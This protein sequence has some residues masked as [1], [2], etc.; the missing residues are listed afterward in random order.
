VHPQPLLRSGAMAAERA[1][2]RSLLR[3]CR[4][5]DQRPAQLVPLL[6]RPPRRYDPR[7][8][9]SL[10]M[11]VTGLPFLEDAVREACG[12]STE[13]C[14]PDGAATRAV[15]R[16]YSRAR[17]MGLPYL[18]EAVLLRRRLE[19]AQAAALEVG[20]G[21]KQAAASIEGAAPEE[22]CE[23]L[24]A[25]E[26]FAPCSPV[27]A[28]AGDFLITHPLS[29]LSE[30]VFDQAVL[31][32]D[33]A[34]E[35]GV[36][37]VVLNKPTGATLGRMLERWQSA[38]DTQWITDLK[39]TDLLGCRLFRG[40]PVIVGGSLKESLRWLHVHGEGVEGAREVAPG[41]WLGGDLREV[42]HR[43]GGD[44]AGVRFFLGFAGWSSLQLR[45]EL[46]CGIW[47]RARAA[48]T[49]LRTRSLCFSPEER[50]AVWRRALL[51]ARRPVF[52]DFPRS[53]GCDKRLRGY[54][55]RLAQLEAQEGGEE[56][57]E[58]ARQAIQGTRPGMAVGSRH[59]R[60]SARRRR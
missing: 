43:A 56:E 15:R 22:A 52:A 46:E 37:G 44:A 29:C 33:S 13:F 2:F 40:G 17:L 9:R 60:L 8:G 49:D 54:M 10:R 45:I 21:S 59:G 23:P 14:H 26:P 34:E 58:E 28:A 31:L 36:T 5:L 47:V 27:Q 35:G 39:L 50:A 11:E 6:G 53:P 18:R 55:E 38:E 20:V 24:P 4:T 51:S 57:E 16:H 19:A 48:G 1:T 3:L 30:S 25:L 32:L 41:V 12:G 42:A 7:Q